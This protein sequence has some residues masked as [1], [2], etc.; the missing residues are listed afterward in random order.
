MFSFLVK[1][2]GLLNQGKVHCIAWNQE[3]GWIAIGGEH[4]PQGQKKGLLKII[5]LDDQ[6]AGIQ[7]QQAKLPY[8]AILEQ[9]M[10]K[11]NIII[12]NE[13]YQKLTTSDD[14]GQIIVWINLGNEWVEE[15]VNN[16]QKSNVTDMKWSPDGFKVGIIYEDGAVIIGSVEGNRL[17]G[18]DYQ[19]RLGLIEWSPDSKLMILGT[20]DGQVII[21]DQNG[22]QLN[23]LKMSCLMGLVDP[24][25]YFAPNQQIAAVQWYE[26]GK[27]YTDETLPGLL[28]A[29]TCGRVQLMKNDKDESPILINTDMTVS[30]VRWSPNGS[31]FA[32]AGSLKEKDDQRAVVQFYSNMGDHL[33]T[34]RVANTDKVNSLSF[35]GDGLRLVMG[36][37]QTV[38]VANLKL[39]YK[40]SYLSQSETL[41]FAYQRQDRM[42]FTIIFWDTR[43]EQKSIRYM[44]GLLD[45]KGSNDCCVLI[46]LV[47]QDTWKVELCNSIGS[48]LDTKFISIDPKYSCMTKTHII[49]ANNDYVYLWQY[50]NQVQRL[51]TFESNQN[52]GIRKIGKEMAWFIDENPDSQVIYDKD[53][54]NLEKQTDEIIC[55]IQANENYLFIGRINGNILKFTLPYVSVE[56]KY[57][58]ENRPNIININCNST[59]LSIIDIMGTIQL[60]DISVASGKLLDFDKKDCWQV[61]WSDNDPLQFAV[62]E[63][64]R[65]HL[66]RDVTAEDPFPCEAFLCS[67]SELTVRGALLD[68]IMMS[69]DGQLRADELLV[70][71]ESRLFKEIKESIQK[72]LPKEMFGII[73]KQPSNTLWQLLAQKALEELDFSVAEKCYLKLEDY[74]GLQ[75]IKRILDYDEKEKQKAEVYVFL[76]RF[77]EAEKILREIERKDLAVQM[78][79]KTG[80]YQRV[81]FLSKDLVGADEV[82]VQTQNKLGNYYCDQGEWEKAQQQ[83]KLSNNI[84]KL[85]ETSFMIEDY[86]TLEELANSMQEGN[87]LLCDLGERFQ[88]LGMAKSAIKCFEKAGDIK[89]A[90]DCAVL[91][92]AWNFAVE[93]AERHNFVQIEGLLQQYAAQLLEQRM[94]L[95]AAELYR[96]ANHNSDA[97]RLLSQIGEDLIKSDQSPLVVKKLFVMA[98][99]E[100]DL[101]K[102]KLYDVTMTAQNNTIAHTLD[103]L[104]TNDLNHSA[105]KVLNNPWRQAEAWHFYILTQKFL[106]SGNYKYALKS[107]IR[108]CEFELD[109]DPK[110]IY[111]LLA[112]AAYYNKSYKECARAFVKLENL[113]NISEEERE[114]YQQVAAQIFV[115]NAPEDQVCDAI[116]CP[117]PS[118]GNKKITEYQLFCKECGTIFGVCVASG[119]SIYG[120][121]FYTC[122][123]CKHK[124][125]DQEVQSQALK[126]CSLCHT[127]IDFNRFGKHGD[128]QL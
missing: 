109:M 41:I 57:F 65:I 30:S 121:K 23:S 82:T 5:K 54:F 99:L 25:N 39:D 86:Q 90:I 17:W 75:F 31:M 47:E 53:T 62:M 32:V 51:T 64:G 37:G 91:L 70:Y 38:Y 71:Y 13:R 118:C 60:L 59:R 6:K 29:Y 112:L 48:P 83:F 72:T 89:K 100:V 124:M 8:E 9:H 21:H 113:D 79:M 87:A 49:I 102:K 80:D 14:Q 66:V 3:E 119:K 58:F 106:Y 44:K 81:L 95:E 115:K 2:L 45:I 120:Q 55:A 34:L 111:S 110:R 128:K 94:K 46:S 104:V 101:Y 122:K 24:K 19:Y 107:A 78:R 7:G 125:I 73:E 98:A 36:V 67:F 126:F 85:I 114:R 28:V 105:D 52:T 40:W 63:K 84:E 103:Q 88:L 56:P 26:Y 20:A 35:E 50:R 77:D 92:N 61:V 93:L 43:R 96:K 127:P 4:A 97:A 22:N 76:K 33:K 117:K 1:K 68:D 116:Q 15:M 27:M 16:R 108:L 12:W 10:G 11:V 74:A 123:A 18:R 69:P 42:E